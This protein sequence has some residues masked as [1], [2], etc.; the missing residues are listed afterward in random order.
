[1]SESTEHARKIENITR[2]M[3]ELASKKRCIVENLPRHGHVVDYR[4]RISCGEPP[5]Q[6]GQP[7]ALDIAEKALPE[8]EQVALL[9]R[10]LADLLKCL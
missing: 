8:D 6:V 4:W 9:L 2:R 3:Q 5:M 7:I 10:K 1:M